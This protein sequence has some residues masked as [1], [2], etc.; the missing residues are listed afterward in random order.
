MFVYNKI[1]EYAEVIDT[2]S[3]SIE[4]KE[5]KSNISYK[6]A[7]IAFEKMCKRYCNE[8]DRK[9]ICWDKEIDSTLV[10]ANIFVNKGIER[11]K[12]AISDLPRNF[13]IRCKNIECAITDINASFALEYNNIS[14]ISRFYDLKN[15]MSLQLREIAKAMEEFSNDYNDN[16]K[17]DDKIYKSIRKVLKRNGIYVKY[18]YCYKNR[19]GIKQMNMTLRT[20]K[21]RVVKSNVIALIVSEI[22]GENMVVS[23]ESRESVKNS[24]CEIVLV[25]ESFF[26]VTTCFKVMKK[27]GEILCGDNYA[28]IDNQCG[29]CSL[30]LS[31]GMGTGIEAFTESKKVIELFESLLMAGFSKEIVLKLIK[32][33]MYINGFQSNTYATVD[34]CIID[35]YTGVCEF[36]K[37]GAASSYIKRGEEIFVIESQD[38]PVGMVDDK[39]VD[40]NKRKY[41]LQSGD[42]VIMMTDGFDETLRN[43]NV[44]VDIKNL[45]RGIK[46]RNPKVIAGELMRYCEI[47]EPLRDDVSILI[48]ILWKNN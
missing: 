23:I 15:T 32:S 45:L 35:K 40:D 12:V 46:S 38:L 26:K 2:M 6:R 24:L 31:D 21:E 22:L 29:Q 43:A 34:A 19:F 36:I 41:Q 9:V 48:G 10:A 33:A 39:S 27:E 14:W 18:M 44:F 42:I 30:I 37:N 1:K 5:R 47:R 16:I 8:C 7:N 11:G 3:K 4:V 25:Q 13:A 20:L 17:L 28:V